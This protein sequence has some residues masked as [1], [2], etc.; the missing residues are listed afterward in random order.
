MNYGGQ[1]FFGYMGNL[2]QDAVDEQIKTVI[3]VGVNFI[4][5]ANIYSEGL[6]KLM[7]GRTMKN[8]DI[9][10]EDLVLAT[11]VRGTLGKSQNDVRV[12]KKHII[13][14]VDPSLKDL[15]VIISI[16]IKSTPSTH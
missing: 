11:K 12:L 10:R 15:L 8:L 1:G 13:Q 4:E 16:F 6:S 3:E 7:I 9:N 14:Q 2:Y 5:A